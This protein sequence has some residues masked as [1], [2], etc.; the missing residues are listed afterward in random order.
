MELADQV[1]IALTDID[2]SAPTAPWALPGCGL[3]TS[4]D[5]LRLG[6]LGLGWAT[7]LAVWDRWRRL[8]GHAFLVSGV[9]YLPLSLGFRL[10]GHRGLFPVS[11]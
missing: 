10:C 7:A 5:T 3:T 8:P 4:H 11:T 2:C 6:L 9:P 1:V